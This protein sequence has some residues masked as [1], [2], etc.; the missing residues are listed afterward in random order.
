M[1]KNEF[2]V[3][4]KK[5]IDNMVAKIE[6]LE[7]KKDSLQENAKASYQQN[8]DE[9]KAKKNNLQKKYAQL[10]DAAEEKWDDAKSAFSTASDSLKDGI[11][12][13]KASMS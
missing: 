9:L 10:E 13:I 5:S 12:K 1:D 2:K 11:D 7:E 6:E 4:A 3:K 8:L